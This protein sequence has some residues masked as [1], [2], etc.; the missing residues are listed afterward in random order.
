LIVQKEKKMTKTKTA[1]RFTEKELEQFLGFMENNDNGESFR[2]FTYIDY[3][4]DKEEYRFIVDGV[5]YAIKQSDDEDDNYN[6]PLIPST[7]R[8]LNRVEKTITVW[9]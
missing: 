6:Q 3:D 1:C 7:L 4:Y 2:D 5:G 9:E 8:L